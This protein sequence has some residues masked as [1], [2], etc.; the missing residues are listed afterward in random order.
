MSPTL[1]PVSARTEEAGEGGGTNL[2]A[3]CMADIA[4]LVT[5]SCGGRSKAGTPG[6]ESVA[7]GVVASSIT[8]S[9]TW[10]CNSPLR[11]ASAADA[12]SSEISSSRSSAGGEGAADVVERL[13]SPSSVDMSCTRS[14][15]SFTREVSGLSCILPDIWEL[16]DVVTGVPGGVSLLVDFGPKSFRPETAGL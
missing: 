13:D 4:F 2:G 11:S 8:T 15:I 5:G 12:G 3:F 14:L 1:E 16:V 10:L 9:P 6:A 7:E